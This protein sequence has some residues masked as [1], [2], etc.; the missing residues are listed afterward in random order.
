L[1]NT[2][3][4]CFICGSPAIALHIGQ[5]QRCGSCGHET[6]IDVDIHGDIVNDRLDRDDFDR[7][8][9][10]DRFKKTVLRE[11]ARSRA[12]L[13]DIGSASGRFLYQNRGEFE[14]SLGIEVTPECVDFSRELGLHIETDL[15]TLNSPVAVVTFWHSL[16]HIPADA[17]EVM[18][19]RI[20]ECST[21]ETV[22]VVSVPN[23]GSLQYSMLKERFAYYDVPHHLHQF[24]PVSLDKLML[25]FGFSRYLEH[26][27][28]SYASFG[29][30]QGLLNLFNSQHDYL[31]YRKKRGWGFGLSPTLRTLLDAY[32]LAL[33][34]LLFIPSIALTLYDLLLLQRGGVLT[35]CYQREKDSK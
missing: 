10:L 16:E 30:L 11:C 24:T 1:K 9:S 29:W 25:K 20:R 32:N 21:K 13:L 5:Y 31:Y 15:A 3:K 14:Q 34:S 26:G 27:S 18:F 28:F 4:T 23:A 17:I 22:V 2:A 35:V 8:N 7:P 6:L 33:A 12:F 19:T